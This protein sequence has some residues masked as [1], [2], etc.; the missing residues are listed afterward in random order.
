MKRG[1]TLIELLVVVLII[2][3]LSAVA[4]PKYQLAVEKARAMQ[5]VVLIKAWAEAEERYYLANG[6]YSMDESA[7]QNS[8]NGDSL[9]IDIS[10]PRGWNAHSYAHLYVAMQNQKS[11]YVISKTMK[12]QQNEEWANRGITCNVGTGLE[13]EFVGKI[14][15]TLCGTGT[16]TQV[17]GS[18]EKGC[19]I[20]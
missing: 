8:F 15:K 19:E 9:D 12:H 11:G 5:A 4:L 20:K 2:G 18:G 1:F 14:C 13:N 7:K 10:I 3:I 6:T 16:L 17:W